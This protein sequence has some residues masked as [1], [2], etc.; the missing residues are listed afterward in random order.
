MFRFIRAL[1]ARTRM[2]LSVLVLLVVA[3]AFFA[4]FTGA[5]PRT[6]ATAAPAGDPHAVTLAQLPAE[7]AETLQRIKS[8]GPF[9]YSRDGVTFGNYEGLLPK[10]KRGYY[11]ES[12]VPTPGAK[13]RGARRIVA[14][15]GK[16]G[17]PA[18]SGE[19]WYSGDHYKSFRRIR[20]K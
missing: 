8:G 7:A 5:P 17:N 11:T 15:K 1:P 20:E 6:P 12:T 4:D 14:G 3:L 19:Y 18:T 2:I 9:P 10:Q 16:T 13:N